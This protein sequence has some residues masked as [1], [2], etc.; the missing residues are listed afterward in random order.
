MTPGTFGTFGLRT[1][2][3]VLEGIPKCPKCVEEGRV[4]ELWADS[5]LSSPAPATRWVGGRAPLVCESGAALPRQC[6]FSN[7]SAGNLSGRAEFFPPLVCITLP[8]GIFPGASAL[9]LDDVEFC[10]P[11]F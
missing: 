1:V 10:L 3:A 11:P 4:L 9:G 2:G 8:L 6:G 5:Q 7:G